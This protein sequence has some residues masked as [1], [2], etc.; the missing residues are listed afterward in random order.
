MNI[1]YI[2]YLFGKKWTGP[3]YSV[4]SQINA[5]SKYDNVFWY[6]INNLF[7][8]R[9]NGNLKCNDIDD[10]PKLKIS[11]LPKPF[12]NPD[13]VI[14]EGLYF[15]SFCKIAKECRRRNIPYIIIPRSSLTEFAQKSKNI[16]KSIAN[17]IF[18]NRFIKN[19][20]AIQYLTSKEYQD[21]GVKWNSRHFIIPN[22]IES[23]NTI[24]HFEDNPM[25]R[26]KGV[27]IGRPD[28]YQKGIDILIESC[29]YLRKELQKNNCIIELYGPEIADNKQR[30][31]KMIDDKGLN[32][33]IIQKNGVFDHEKEEILKNS[34]FFILTSRFE[35][36]PMGLIEA[37]SFGVPCLV[38]KGT[39]MAHEIKEADAGWTADINSKSLTDAIKILL[40]DSGSFAEKGKNA[41]K[42]SKK[43]NWDVLAKESHQ[44]YKELIETN[45]RIES[46]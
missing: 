4:P 7:K 46:I 16:K 3:N 13:L 40:N 15:F 2:T 29:A 30:I 24:K 6:N 32:H 19:A 8:D 45:K 36:H 5:Q 27:F 34:D 21:S 9:N 42:L 43:Y 33:I 31:Q 41:L 26:L 37:L 20:D 39:N 35:G 25:A 44:R 17:L 38:T 10:Y 1:L 22:G 11:E 12:N 18:F 14:F 23:K 28:I